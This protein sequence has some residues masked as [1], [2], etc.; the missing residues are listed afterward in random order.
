MGNN[1]GNVLR[2]GKLIALALTSATDSTN[3]PG[4]DPIRS[5]VG[6]DVTTG[7]NILVQQ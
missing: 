2:P 7:V 4:I 6:E 3:L 1:L 5:N